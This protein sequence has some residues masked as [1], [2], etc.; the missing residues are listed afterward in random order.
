LNKP[1]SVPPKNPRLALRVTSD[2]NQRY[3]LI[4]QQA[5]IVGVY[6]Q[7][8]AIWPLGRD[9]DLM[10]AAIDIAMS[11]L[12]PALKVIIVQRNKPSARNGEIKC[13]LLG[14]RNG[15][16]ASSLPS[17]RLCANFRWQ[18]VK[19]CRIPS[20]GGQT[21]ASKRRVSKEQQCHKPYGKDMNQSDQH[22]PPLSDRIEIQWVPQKRHFDHSCLLDVAP[23][24]PGLIDSANLMSESPPVTCQRVLQ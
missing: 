1:A 17:L 19:M 12:V 21:T 18:V 24:I 3:I 11:R 9:I 23:E 14:S 4:E 5:D 20:V 8:S 2:F 16:S 7:H 10:Q 15:T 22:H 6:G 13:E